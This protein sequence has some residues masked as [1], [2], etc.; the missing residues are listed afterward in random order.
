MPHRGARGVSVLFSVAATEVEADVWRRLDRVIE[1]VLVS[2]RR[3][4]H[5]LQYNNAI[6]AI[7]RITVPDW[8]DPE[9]E[10]IPRTTCDLASSPRHFAIG[11]LELRM[12]SS[13]RLS[14]ILR[15][16]PLA[17]RV[18][19]ASHSASGRRLSQE[20]CNPERTTT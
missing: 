17:E 20:I 7:M 15:G 8:G 11:R 2:V 5:C 4:N 10:P 9:Q 1:D 13:P 19:F 14:V 12:I 6:A 16:G 3:Q 18:S